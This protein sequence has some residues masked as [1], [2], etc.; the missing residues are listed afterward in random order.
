MKIFLSRYFL[1]VLPLIL[2]SLLETFVLPPSFFTFRSWEALTFTTITPHLCNFYPNF[3]LVMKEEGDLGYNTNKTL[4]KNTIWQTD[5]IGNRNDTFYSDPDILLI[6]DSFIAGSSLSQSETISNKIALKLGYKAKVYNIAPGTLRDFDMLY[7]K[8]IIKKPK[9]LIYSIGERNIPP[10]FDP[11]KLSNRWLENIINSFCLDGWNVN[12]DRMTR[13]YSFERLKS[14][15]QRKAGKGRQ[16]PI[17]STM[18]FR[19]DVHLHAT[20]DLNKTLSIISSYKKYCESNNISFLF[21]PIPDKQTVYYDLVPLAHQPDYLVKL[22]TLLKQN[23]IPAIN[24]LN[25]YI[26][27]RAINNPVLYQYDDNHWN[28]KAVEIVTDE[29]IKYLKTTKYYQTAS[30]GH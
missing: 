15:I 26:K 8:G 27:E 4:I 30:S 12:I 17:D 19:K 21:L 3:K 11:Y 5:K 20:E 22:D 28:V 14:I 10:I 7:K 18:L 6:G 24:V 1:F 16:S 25:L 23:G 13:F 2:L 9:I 29:I